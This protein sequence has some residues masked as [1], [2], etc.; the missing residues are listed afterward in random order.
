MKYN[1]DI[2][3]TEVNSG[4]T[5]LCTHHI[6]FIESKNVYVKQKRVYDR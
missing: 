3:I 2:N 1:T 6:G 5:D 4:K